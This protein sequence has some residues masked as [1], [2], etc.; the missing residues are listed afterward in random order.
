MAY[1]LKR[2][3]DEEA[4]DPNAPPG[5]P[6]VLGGGSALVSGAPAQ[7][8]P[9]SGSQFVN[10]DRIINANKDAA[11]KSVANLTGA[12]QTNAKNARGALAGMV[13]QFQNAVT[14]GT[15]ANPTQPRLPPTPA[16]PASSVPPTTNT[17]STT[18]RRGNT[19]GITPAAPAPTT[20]P[21]RPVEDPL[22]GA[23]TLAAAQDAAAKA[24][25]S[26]PTDFTKDPGFADMWQKIGKSDDDLALLNQNGGLGALSQRYLAGGGDYSQGMQDMDAALFGYTGKPGFDQVQ[27]EYGDSR[28][29]VD[30]AVGDAGKQVEHA[31]GLAADAKKFWD[32]KIEQ[33][34]VDTTQKADAERHALSK[35][36]A[37]DWKTHQWVD[38]IYTRLSHDNGFL[39]IGGR[40]D[41]NIDAW[42]RATKDGDWGDLIKIVD[43][44]YGPGAGNEL[45]NAFTDMQTGHNDRR[46]RYLEL[47]GSEASLPHSGS[48]PEGLEGALYQGYTALAPWLYE[49]QMKRSGQG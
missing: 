20:P 37:E 7:Q 2:K 9:T 33:N 6:A 22:G 1:E 14:A 28:K 43:G 16:M 48:N 25:Y 4:V 30:R 21:V 44:Y 19:D 15:P 3:E 18:P 39:G 35:Q 49:E 32:S 46:K 12:L 23:P 10:F 34:K 8:Q 42:N 38:K 40:Q 36:I 13:G 24:V 26:G 5:T 31:Q 11:E 17:F 29:L 45:K 47:G 27:R 41:E